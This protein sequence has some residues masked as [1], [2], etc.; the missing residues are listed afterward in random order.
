M[1][2]SKEVAAATSLLAA[3]ACMGP[4]DKPEDDDWGKVRALTTLDTVD[5][6]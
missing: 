6:F 5:R 2:V 4:R 3:P 1:W